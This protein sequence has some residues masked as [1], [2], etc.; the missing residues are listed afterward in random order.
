[1]AS[2]EFKVGD[3]VRLKTSGPFMTILRIDSGEAFPVVCAWFTKND[4]YQQAAFPV[5]V[6]E[7]VS[8][9]SRTGFQF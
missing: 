3:L 1:M 7:P 8:D 5:E 4:E 2:N 9:E 6:L